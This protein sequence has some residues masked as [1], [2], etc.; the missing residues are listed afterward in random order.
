MP[1]LLFGSICYVADI[2]FCRLRQCSY[3]EVEVGPVLWTVDFV[4]GI[5]Y[6]IASSLRCNSTRGVSDSTY[7]GQRNN[8]ENYDGKHIISG[9]RQV[10]IIVS[11]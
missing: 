2:Y 4:V 7:A 6:Q 1:G 8:F 11:N 10:K 3:L 9:N 5:S